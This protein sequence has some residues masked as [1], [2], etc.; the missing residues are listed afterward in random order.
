MPKYFLYLVGFKTSGIK[1]KWSYWNQ[2]GIWHQ[3]ILNGTQPETLWLFFPTALTCRVVLPFSS[4]PGEIDR[5]L[6]KVAEG[7]EQFEDIWQKVSNDRL[8]FRTPVEDLA[9][10]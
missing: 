10:R 3:N 2:Y 8:P 9:A 5:C 7:V 6:K 1:I 4:P